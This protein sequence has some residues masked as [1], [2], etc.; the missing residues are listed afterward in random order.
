ML[1]AVPKLIR[2]ERKAGTI[3]V[4]VKVN[5][6]RG[7][8]GCPSPGPCFDASSIYTRATIASPT[9][10]TPYLSSRQVRG[11]SVFQTSTMMA[12]PFHKDAL[13]KGTSE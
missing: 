9:S 13:S 10:P 2:G 8:I 4:K 6:K 5:R 12:L 11:L 7:L 3:E 1:F